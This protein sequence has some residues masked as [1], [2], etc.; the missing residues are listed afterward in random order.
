MFR[1]MG[2]DPI[3]PSIQGAQDSASASTGRWLGIRSMEFGEE[4]HNSLPWRD[5]GVGQG[6]SFHGGPGNA[7]ED[8]QGKI[9]LIV[10]R[11]RHHR[12]PT[13]SAETGIPNRDCIGERGFSATVRVMLSDRTHS[14]GCSDGESFPVGSPH[15][16][17][18]LLQLVSASRQ[19]QT[20][21]RR[22]RLVRE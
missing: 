19:H 6:M 14:G 22:K 10:Q 18:A 2:F 12:G 3:K 15:L 11:L 17:I 21:I 9:R 8:R 5:G 20:E 13:A 4:I 1:R 16:K 7:R